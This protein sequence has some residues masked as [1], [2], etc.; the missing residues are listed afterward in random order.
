MCA[1]QMPDLAVWAKGLVFMLALQSLLSL[2]L[3]LLLFGALDFLVNMCDLCCRRGNG[4]R[5]A[6][7]GGIV[8]PCVGRCRREW[9]GAAVHVDPGAGGSGPAPAGHLHPDHQ[10]EEQAASPRCSRRVWS[11]G[12]SGKS[13]HQDIPSYLH[14]LKYF[15]VDSTFQCTRQ[16]FENELS[17]VGDIISILALRFW[18]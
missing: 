6:S 4:S 17:L 1:L 10:E 16:C 3:T 2:G 12:L 14:P 8:H 5:V 13:E 11:C 9:D 15:D 7:G 18:L